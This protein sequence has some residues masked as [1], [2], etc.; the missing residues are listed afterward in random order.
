M[1]VSTTL[2]YPVVLLLL[3]AGAGL[4][5]DRAS[6]RWLPAA[7]LPA[8]G[9][10]AL[11]AVSQV[12]TYISP[13]A[14][15]TPYLMLAVALAG[16]A[17]GMPR[18]RA[19]AHGSSATWRA[20]GWQLAA[21][22]LVYV[23]ALAPVL[24][25]GRPTFSSYM[26][27]AD[28][29]VHML[30]ADYLIHHGQQY[31]HLDL[32]NSYGQFVNDYYN[33][34]YPSGSDTLFGGSALLLRL[35]L[36]WAFQPLNAF[37][38]ACAAGP[39][40][41]LARGIGLR[42]G[43]AALAALTAT[44]PALVYAY[45]LLGSIKEVT[46][47]CMILALGA[48]AVLHRRWL[49]GPTVGVLPFALVSAAG[50]SALGVGF[51]VW[52]LVAL[53]AL[54]GAL[55]GD[56][57][58]GR[59]HARGVVGMIAAG[60]LVLLVGALPTWLD[61]SGSLRVAQNIAST[62]NPGNLRRPLQATQAFGVWLRGSYKQSP[63]GAAL[64]FTRGLIVLAGALCVLGVVHLVRRRRLVLAGWLAL[65][66]VAWLAVALSATTWVK[67]KQEMLTSPAVVL[68][69][70]AGIA[71]LLASSR[72][73][74]RRWVAALA[75]LVLAGGVLASDLAQYHSANLAPTSRYQEMATLD[76]RFG[77]RG[78]TLVTDFDEYALYVMRDLD[79]GG[80]NF[81][82]PPPAL[83]ALAGGYGRPV[84]LDRAPPA[85]LSAYPLIITRRDPTASPPPAAYR[86]VWRGRFYEVW[87][88]SPGAHAAY[89]HVALSDAPASSCAAIAG[90][91]RVAAHNATARGRLIA[92]RSPELVSIPLTSA[93]HPA[94][95]GHQRQGLVMSRPGSLAAVFTVPWAGDWVLWLKG[96]LMPAIGVKVD[97]RALGSVSG[98]LD[99]NS[100]VPDTIS[101][102]TVRL[103]AGRHRLMLRRGGFS[104]APG[105]GGSAVLDA[106]FLT[107]AA[108]AARKLREAPV[109]R[110][111]S[112]C[113]SS[114]QWL[115]LL[116]E[117]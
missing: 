30:G 63:S 87:E 22:A 65:M 102:A 24:L 77:G 50:I 35:S 67:A 74:V 84:Q 115:E 92:A 106:V 47:L 4:L 114:D 68:I 86:P 71:A 40:W 108:L 19:L 117:A 13:L 44:V 6:G 9:A 15:A 105:N 111:R 82:Y 78:P 116:S 1:F 98:Q 97:G 14:P 23:L 73:T 46:A 38:L 104:L 34:S 53:G 100:L 110:W 72:V 57:R 8:V 93:S 25:A 113:G 90:V 89:A 16:L 88:R 36:I 20:R 112:L 101:A 26:A 107:P 56:V 54:V 33:T 109:A 29:A 49:A 51:S 60:T 58:A 91:A 103:S 99:G 81:A 42:G 52:I 18:L 17:L 64:G 11:I 94:G 48:L 66:L 3:C 80:P 10:A 62:G 69:V 31:A 85:S 75:A 70:W 12:S 28:S 83:A 95:W 96:Q 79:V 45:E 41:V 59:V 5:V 55:A 7:L 39:A 27:L 2:A 61:L 76:H 32:R 43:W 37:M 21:P